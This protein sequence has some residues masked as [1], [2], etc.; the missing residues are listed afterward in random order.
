MTSYAVFLDRSSAVAAASHSL[1]VEM[2]ALAYGLEPMH[3]GAPFAAPPL[4]VGSH[5]LYGHTAASGIG[6]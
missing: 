5:T 2:R 6:P 1:L 4:H 3:N